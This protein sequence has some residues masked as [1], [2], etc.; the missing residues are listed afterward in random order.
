EI[1]D[2]VRLYRNPAQTMEK[3]T[4]CISGLQKFPNLG[5]FW[6]GALS[7]SQNSMIPVYIPNLK[8]SSSKLLDTTLVNYV[9]QQE[10]PRL[11]FTVKTVILCYIDI[12]DM[13]EIQTFI[14]K[15]NDTPVDIVLCDL[16]E[17]LDQ[18]VAMDEARFHAEEAPDGLLPGWR[19]TVDRFESDRVRQ[20]IEDFNEKSRMSVTGKKTFHPVELS[21]DGLEMIEFL[22]VDCTADAGPWHS[23]SEIFIDGSGFVTVNGTKTKDPWDGTIHSER[24]PLRLKIRNIC[25]DESEWKSG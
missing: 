15:N 23:D 19:I 11:D 21:E 9:I 10:L 17:E 3:I 4:D 7:D 1:Q 20:K 14:R 16:K 12:T 6:A 22:S 2:G 8:D 25:G 24:K 5:S 18:F 13:K